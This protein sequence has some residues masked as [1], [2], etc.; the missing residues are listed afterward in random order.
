MLAVGSHD[1]NIYIYEVQGN[2]YQLMGK[3]VAHNSFITNMDWSRDS[4][5]IQSNCGAYELLFFDVNSKQQMKNGAT[6]LRD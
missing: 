6:Q 1:N 4:R 5:Y 3:L 2:S